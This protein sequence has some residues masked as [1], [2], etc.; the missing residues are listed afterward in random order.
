ML[1]VFTSVRVAYTLVSESIL[2]PSV[3]CCCIKSIEDFRAQRDME[4]YVIEVTEFKFDI[5]CGLGGCFEATMASEVTILVSRGNMHMD[6]RVL[7]VADFK[8]DVKFGLL[9]PC[10]TLAQ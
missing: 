7:K 1:G 4:T 3:V 2:Y 10:R 9:R 8:F 6:Y 5:R